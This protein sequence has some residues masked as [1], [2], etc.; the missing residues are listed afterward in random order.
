MLSGGDAQ[1][2]VLRPQLCP[3]Q[4]RAWLLSPGHRQH[5]PHRRGPAG[6][7]VQCGHQRSRGQWSQWR[8]AGK[9]VLQRGPE[10]GAQHGQGEALQ[11]GQQLWAASAGVVR[12]GQCRPAPGL[13]PSLCSVSYNYSWGEK[14]D[15]RFIDSSVGGEMRTALLSPTCGIIT[16]L[17]LSSLFVSSGFH[18]FYYINS[19]SF[20]PSTV[21]HYTSSKYIIVA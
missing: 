15:T 3:W 2:P 21:Y 19:L 9:R 17:W 16:Y 5:Q 11:E 13:T 8:G 4:A 10:R 12:V 6:R 18:S 14:N 7:Q 1:V 20:F